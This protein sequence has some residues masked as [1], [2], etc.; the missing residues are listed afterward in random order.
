MT[1]VL[2]WVSVVAFGAAVAYLLIAYV[3]AVRLSAPAHEPP[4][5]T[6]AD[7]GLD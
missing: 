6:P 4:E 5:R 1:R 7:V 2:L 3:V